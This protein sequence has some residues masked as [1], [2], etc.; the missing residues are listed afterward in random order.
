MSRRNQKLRENNHCKHKSVFINYGIV[1]LFIFFFASLTILYI[2]NTITLA[3]LGYQRLELENYKENLIEDNKRLELTVETLARIDRIEEIACN[4]LG[5]IR[6]KEVKFVAS[7]PLVEVN[8]GRATETI[9]E[10]NEGKRPLLA[11][12]NLEKFNQLIYSI[13]K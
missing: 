8:L 6:P 13:L 7:L 10:H 4:H 2:S 3:E 1:L 11:I 9:S 12:V 5:M